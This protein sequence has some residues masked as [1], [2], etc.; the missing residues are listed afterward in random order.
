MLQQAYRCVLVRSSSSYMSDRSGANVSEGR[1]QRC[2]VGNAPHFKC[3]SYHASVSGRYHQMSYLDPGCMTTKELQAEL[4]YCVWRRVLVLRS[5]AM[6]ER[7]REERSRFE[8]KELGRCESKQSWCLY[9]A[10]ARLLSFGSILCSFSEAA[11]V[12]SP[13]V[14]SCTLPVSGLRPRP[15]QGH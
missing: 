4:W 13:P 11:A 7:L 15:L 12:T 5:H 10:F 1:P 6:Q 2:N 9:I 8:S 3:I 14:P